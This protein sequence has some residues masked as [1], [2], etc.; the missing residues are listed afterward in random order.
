MLLRPGGAIL[1]HP[2]EFQA[3]A[4]RANTGSRGILL[5]FP[6]MNVLNAHREQD[7]YWCST[8]LFLFASLT[9]GKNSESSIHI[10]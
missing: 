9:L 4:H 8:K 2:I 6:S 5:P 7:F 1:A 3:N 10:H